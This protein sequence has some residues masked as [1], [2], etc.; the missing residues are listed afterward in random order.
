MPWKLVETEDGVFEKKFYQARNNLAI[1][2]RKRWKRE[3]KVKDKAEKVEKKRYDKEVLKPLRIS[4]ERAKAGTMRHYKDKNTS[5]QL[6]LLVTQMLKQFVDEMRGRPLVE[7]QVESKDSRLVRKEQ[8]GIINS[9]IQTIRQ[10]R[11]LSQTLADDESDGK[12][13]NLE[14]PENLIMLDEA[15]DLLK[16]AG[17]KADI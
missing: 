5:R 17:V 16:K 4:K 11:E 1:A 12:V 7:Y 15:R 3:R 9:T 2:A 8:L 14:T 10:L 13:E 6:D